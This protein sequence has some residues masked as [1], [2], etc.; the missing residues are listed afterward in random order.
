[1]RE[2]RVGEMR[3][4]RRGKGQM[5]KDRRRKTGRTDSRMRERR[6]G[7][8]GRIGGDRRRGRFKVTHRRKVE[9][10]KKGMDEKIDSMGQ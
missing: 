10:E 6:V 4:D 9:L 8:L 5:G 2:R 7:D 1:M 3:Q